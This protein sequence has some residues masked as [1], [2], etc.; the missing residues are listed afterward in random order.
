MNRNRTTPPP[1]LPA[2]GLTRARHPSPKIH[3]ERGRT[4]YTVSQL[5]RATGATP[6]AIRHYV[7][8]ELLRPRRD[9]GND[10]KLFDEMDVKRVLFIRRA[11]GLGFSLRDIELIFDHSAQG[12]SPCPLV[13]EV[14][15]TRI[16]ENRA[17]LDEMKQLLERMEE[18]LARW[19]RMPDGVPD[20]EAICHLIESME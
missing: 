17:R 5:A 9:P 4:V 6:D 15:Q 12:S 11:Q 2:M 18:A 20:G 13:R 8:I 1:F 16:E 14:I 7:R 10:Y 3:N 19:S